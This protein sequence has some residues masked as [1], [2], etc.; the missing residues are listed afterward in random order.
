[1]LVLVQLLQL[2]EYLQMW[3]ELEIFKRVAKKLSN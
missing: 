2:L 1:V 3:L